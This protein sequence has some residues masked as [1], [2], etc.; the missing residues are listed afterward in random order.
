VGAGVATP[1]PSALFLQLVQKMGSAIPVDS[2]HRR[3]HGR[4]SF[5]PADA[6]LGVP[7]KI[8]RALSLAEA[9]QDVQRSVVV[10]CQACEFEW[11]QT[12]ATPLLLPSP[13]AGAKH[14]TRT[15]VSAST[16]LFYAAVAEAAANDGLVNGAFRLLVEASTPGC[17]TNAGESDRQQLVV[18]LSIRGLQRTDRVGE[19]GR[20]SLARA[21]TPFLYCLRPRQRPRLRTLPRLN[22]PSSLPLCSSTDTTAR[23]VL[24][25]LAPGDGPRLTFSQGVY[26]F[27]ILRPPRSRVAFLAVADASL[28]R[29]APFALLEDIAA[30][31]GAPPIT[32]GLE[33]DR[34]PET[35]PPLTPPS[36]DALAD[37]L[38]IYGSGAGGDRVAK[39][40]GELDHVRAMVLD[41]VD[42][43]LERG[44]RLDALSSAA[45]GLQLDALS[46]RGEARRLR[47]EQQWRA[48]KSTAVMAGGAGLGL[49]V[50]AATVCG[51]GLRCGG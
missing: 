51:W 9:P 7:G 43:V 10:T 50:L 19:T 25:G 1:R 31:C 22:H 32:V 5:F 14:G 35:A 27:H 21:T 36:A 45:E 30:R 34:D 49:Y 40:R 42:R 4:T 28:G 23:Q 24:S 6:R 41:N 39:V 16:A 11:F 15:R 47:I 26:V 2:L 12:P 37:A 3:A 29:A 17:P 46:F 48:A 20:M 8:C 38:K 33:H 13:L 44:E 18:Q